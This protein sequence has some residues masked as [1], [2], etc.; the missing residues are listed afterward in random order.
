MKSHGATDIGK[1]RSVNQDYFY[2]SDKPVGCFP[3]LYIVA[4][5]MGG[6]KA[7]DKASSLAVDRF[8][9]LAAETG[10]EFPFEAMKK[11]I[12]RVNQEVYQ[13]SLEQPA[14]EGMGTTFVLAT[15]LGDKAYIMNIGDSRCYYYD[16]SLRQI[17][18]DH[19][20]VEEMVR[21][22]ELRPE[23][24]RNHPQKNIITRAVG[25]AD[26]VEPD[27]FL[28]D[29]PPGSRILLCSD[30]LSNM[31]DD[32]DLSA[33]LAMDLTEEELVR[34][35]IDEALFFG[36]LDNITVVAARRE[37]GRDAEC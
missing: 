19:S 28:A 23:E 3:N 34:K 26:D 22:G 12:L 21:A 9:E 10:N 6:H 31:V 36:G 18:L 16:G 5:G 32:E 14:Y 20:L 30:G 29:C 2:C 8:V 27:F 33:F 37:D 15:V 24:S 35:C 17:T 11:I 7:G 4:D 1:K 25:V 13:L